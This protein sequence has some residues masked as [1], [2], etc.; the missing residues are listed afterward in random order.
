MYFISFDYYDAFQFF[1]QKNQS[2][3]YKQE[4]H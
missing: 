3:E 1:K 4:D 2:K